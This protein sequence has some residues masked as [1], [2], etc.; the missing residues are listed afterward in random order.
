LEVIDIVAVA[1]ITHEAGATLVVDNVFLTPFTSTAS[2]QLSRP[3]MTAGV[4]KTAHS[5]ERPARAGFL[6]SVGNAGPSG[7]FSRRNASDAKRVE[8]RCRF[9][10]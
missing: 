5:P 8:V 10:I 9:T 7:Y 2:G 4:S 3:A 1:K 6:R